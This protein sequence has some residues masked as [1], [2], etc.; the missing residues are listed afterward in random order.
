MDTAKNRDKPII[1]ITMGDP[2]GIGPEIII[3]TFLDKKIYNICRPLVIGDAMVLDKLIQINN[4][5]LKINRINDLRT[6]GE[7]KDIIDL[8]DMDN[9]K[10]NDVE[11]GRPASICG[12]AV[13]GY[14]K[15]GV[16]LA[17]K[18]EIDGIVT[19]PINKEIMNAAG[20]HYP[21]HT[22]LLA[23]LS[24][25]KDFRMMMVGGL[26]RIM[27]VTT[28]VSMRELSP[29]IKKDKILTTI[30][31]AYI[32]A[33]N[34]FGI[35]E[36]TIAVSGFNPHAGEHGI[37]GMEEEEE[38]LPAIIQAREEGIN[39]T[40]PLPPDTLFY[41]ALQG[42]YDIVVSMYHDQGLIPL[43]MV[44]FG[45]A[46]NVTVGI[47]FIRTSVDHGTAYDIAGKWLADPASLIEAVKMAAM[48]AKR[49]ST[50]PS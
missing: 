48:L 10:L 18:K 4:Q 24:H 21:G 43:K 2:A 9:I 28:H 8:I 15:K 49:L 7:N 16:E 50:S 6:G 25:T 22:E 37:F 5:S 39:V 35:I 23:A 42:D 32:A 45:R 3:K 17:L 30:R 33:K 1:A 14:I 40:D 47:P 13:V 27:L 46:V 19:A 12:H 26:L 31:L 44:A 34:Y 20:F 41:K 36:P 38:I 11:S 29:L